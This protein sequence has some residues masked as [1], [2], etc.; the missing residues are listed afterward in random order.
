MA[1]SRFIKIHCNF[2]NFPRTFSVRNGYF[3]FFD[4]DNDGTKELLFL[5]AIDLGSAFFIDVKLN[6]I[7]YEIDSVVYCGVY[8]L[9]HDGHPEFWCVKIGTS[10][11]YSPNLGFRANNG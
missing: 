11:L 6:M 7:K 10:W 9:D 8:D 2:F 3:G 4:I 5:P 1:L